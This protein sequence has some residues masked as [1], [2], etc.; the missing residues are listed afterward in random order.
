MYFWSHGLLKTWLHEC[1]KSDVSENPLTS[2]ILKMPND[3]WSLNGSTF[4]KFIDHCE[5]NLDKKESL[6]VICKILGLFVN[7]LTADDK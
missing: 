2:N 4:T 3:C 1:L 7:I 5:G 6:L